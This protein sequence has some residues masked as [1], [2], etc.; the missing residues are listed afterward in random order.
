[1]LLR[2]TVVNLA[3]VIASLAVAIITTAVLT[4]HL[5]AAGFGLLAL[6]RAIVGNAGIV[7]TLFGTG[8]TRYVAYYTGTNDIAMRDRF[9]GTAFAV[10][11]L[12]GIVISIGGI[13]IALL[14]F[15]HVFAG[16]PSELRHEGRLMLSAFLIVLTIQLAS[17]TLG[18]VLEGLQAYAA[19]RSAEAV[20]QIVTLVLLV[21][22]FDRFG[23]GSVHR[24]VWAYGVAEVIRLLLFLMI[25]RWHGVQLVSSLGR[26]RWSAFK[27]LIRF[28]QPLFVAKLATML[29][30]RGD[31][32]LLGIFATIQAVANYQVANQVWS[33][34][35][36]GLSALT[37]A[38]FPAIAERAGGASEWIGSMF[39]RASRYSLAVTLSLATLVIYCRT[40]L[41]EHWVGPLYAG[42]EILIVLFM[43]Q[44]VIAYHQGVSGVA[45]LGVNRHH[46]VGKY[47]AVGA[48]LNFAVSLLLIRR[49]GAVGLLLGAIVKA[50][51][52]MPL[53]TNLALK[54]LD[55][56]WRAYLSESIFP[57]WRFFS[58]TLAVVL[59]VKTLAWT[60]G[61]QTP[62]FI[63]QIAIVTLGMG[64]LMWMMVLTAE[65]RKRLV[66]TVTL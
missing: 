15:D 1:M 39:L 10:N 44:L 25:T 53:Y 21:G 30:S 58:A 63:I 5:G 14:F 46:P 23:S 64:A 56:S 34:A 45:V 33:A 61:S 19:L 51:V 2:N 60:T 62:A 32:V 42:A 38:L 11:L 24:I 49:L 22:Y 41:I 7:E 8:T 50:C 29:S 20:V 35:L 52:V 55:I 59:I 27:D 66:R 18:R 9:I 57:V 4:R 43:I 47:E 16:V 3:S 28:G 65:D 17:V 31:A 12:Q 48:A 40:F 54:R 13:V 26:V 36:A 6:V 37:N